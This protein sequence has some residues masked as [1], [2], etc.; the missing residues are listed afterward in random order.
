MV[1]KIYLAFGILLALF[2]SSVYAG[3]VFE[4][5][6]GDTHDFGTISQGETV[7]H[8]FPFRNP[9]DDTL[10]ILNVKAS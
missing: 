8:A 6:K 4:P 9:G 1:K 5:M 7:V 3:P 2:S 10:R